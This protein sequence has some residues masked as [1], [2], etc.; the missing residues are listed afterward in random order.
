MRGLSF[1][2]CRDIY[3][4]GNNIQIT[5]IRSVRQKYPSEKEETNEANETHE[6][7]E[8]EHDNSFDPGGVHDVPAGCLCV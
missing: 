5:E 7:H 1:P 3:G 2:R 8:K 6:A 4:A